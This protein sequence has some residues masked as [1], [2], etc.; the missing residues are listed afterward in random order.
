M[1]LTN[2]VFFSGSELLLSLD[3]SRYRSNVRN[4]LTHLKKSEI[5]AVFNKI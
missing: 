4:E 5:T 2:S 1:L 3:F